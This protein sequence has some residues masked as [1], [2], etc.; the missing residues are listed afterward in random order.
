MLSGQVGA[1]PV[2]LTL[3]LAGPLLTLKCGQSIYRGTS[4]RRSGPGLCRWER[5]T[6]AW[7]ILELLWTRSFTKV[8]HGILEI[9]KI[10]VL[11]CPDR[12][13]YIEHMNEG[14]GISPPAFELLW[15]FSYL[16]SPFEVVSFE[17]QPNILRMQRAFLLH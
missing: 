7:S 9:S 16:N 10:K 12:L 2:L 13:H 8:V 5:Y 3:R 4:P 1:I 14:H 15:M 6:I 17:D 11:Y